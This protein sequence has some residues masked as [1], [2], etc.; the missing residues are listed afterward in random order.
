MKL[1]LGKIAIPKCGAILLARA[2]H[3]LRRV[4]KYLFKSSAVFTEKTY[5]KAVKKVVENEFLASVPEMVI[6]IKTDNI[7]KRHMISQTTFR[8]FKKVGRK[9]RQ[10]CRAAK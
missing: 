8:F 9:Q 10:K 5:E 3:K 7:H 6:I 4:K 1:L 2:C